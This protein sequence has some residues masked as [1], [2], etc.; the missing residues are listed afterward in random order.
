MTGFLL[1]AALLIAVALGFILPTLLRKSVVTPSHALRAEVNLTVLRDQLR[2][3]DADLARGNIDATGYQSARHE[4]EQRVAEDV[5]PVAAMSATASRRH[6]SALAVTVLVPAIAVS[7]YLL[8]G[9][10]TGINPERAA[11]AA[12]AG[13]E[14]TE[15]QIASMVAGLAQRLKDR[16]DDVEGWTMLARSYHAMGRYPDAVAA[17][18]H[19][20]G[21]TPNNA[22]AM[23][24]YAVA[25][26]MAQGK[27]LH[28]E[29]EQL[30]ARALVLDP[31]NVKALSL[32]GS[33]AFE[34]GDY[35]VAA[36]Q[37][38]KILALV[39]SN[40]DTARLTSTGIAE[41]RGLAGGARTAAATPSASATTVSGTVVLDPALR[42]RVAAT[43][44][45]FIFARA[46]QG[47]R[48]PLAVLRRQVKDLPIT[49]VLDDSMS[50]VPEAKLSGYPMLIVGAR[51]SAS[52]SATP[53]A[54]DF[55][56]SLDAVP[57]GSK[58]LA[59]NINT[60]RK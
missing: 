51:I 43:D 54:G 37:W 1:T 47:P 6:W 25:V 31:N 28:G 30:I 36:T 7:T 5:T 21:L 17:Y 4:L 58:K 32:S 38:E 53:S 56:G 13:A 14:V 16:P 20:I 52:G 3:L 59:I 22:D 29:P 57:T 10:P 41:A 48:F 60:E 34:R 15:Q 50:V 18:K 24:D 49:F 42:S 40:S 39:P 8:V 35:A 45:V 46:A 11:G 9:N 12:T 23:A 19:L 44:T 55:E 2:E 33:A 27:K 26:G